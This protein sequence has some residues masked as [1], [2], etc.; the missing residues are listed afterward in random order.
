MVCKS[1]LKSLPIAATIYCPLL[2]FQPLNMLS[3]L[4]FTAIQYGRDAPAL[5]TEGKVEFQNIKTLMSK[6]WVF[7]FSGTEEKHTN[8]D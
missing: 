6:S 1:L 2:V 3:H 5:V 7:T 8:Q 4:I